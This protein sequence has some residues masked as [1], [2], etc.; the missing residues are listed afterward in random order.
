MF[1]NVYECTIKKKLIMINYVYF[2]VL[3]LILEQA[4]AKNSFKR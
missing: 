4:K 3:P 2:R 1:N